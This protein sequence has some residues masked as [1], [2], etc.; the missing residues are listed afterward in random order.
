MLDNLSR[1]AH[2]HDPY[3]D[4]DEAMQRWAVVVRWLTVGLAVAALLGGWVIF[5]AEESFIVIV[6]I[7]AGLTPS[8]W[9]YWLRG[10]FLY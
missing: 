4:F 8:D 1:D 2:T 9:E 5:A 3:A 6:D 7:C 10:C